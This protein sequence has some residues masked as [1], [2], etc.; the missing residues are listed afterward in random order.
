[1]KTILLCIGLIGSTGAFDK[2]E[3]TLKK[4]LKEKMILDLTKVKLHQKFVDYVF[5]RFTICDSE[6]SITNIEGTHQDVI[7]AVK[8]KL[9]RMEITSSYEE[10]KFYSFK[11]TFEKQ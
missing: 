2:Q 1:M 5:V 4:E 7:E 9:S 8:I 3:S 11:F 6:I 10:D